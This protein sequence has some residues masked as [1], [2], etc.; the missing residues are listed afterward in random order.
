MASDVPAGTVIMV[1]VGV[2]SGR[3]N[4]RIE[5]RGEDARAFA[6]ALKAARTEEVRH[7]LPPPKLGEF[8]GFL[9]R[10]PRPLAGEFDLSMEVTVHFGIIT[11]RVE[12][13]IRQWRD[14]SGLEQQLIERA[15]S[16]GHGDVLEKRG[17]RRTVPPP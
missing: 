4:P 7:S 2:F 3:A 13:G 6:M 10:V 12:R 9:I 17:V 11:E 15:Y 5:V 8:Y 1:E 14:R 16:Q